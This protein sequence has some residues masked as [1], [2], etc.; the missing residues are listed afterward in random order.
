MARVTFDEERCKGC[1]I[2][3]KFCPR[4]I[5]VLAEHFNST[6]F[7]PATVYEQERCT[8][9]AVCAWMCP[10]VVIE[11]AV[12]RGEEVDVESVNEG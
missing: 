5:I 11:V 6:G 1:G 3:V 10:D 8:G 2:C 4:G 7:H 12:E 9:C